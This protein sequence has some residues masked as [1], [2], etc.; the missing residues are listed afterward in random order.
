MATGDYVSVSSQS[1]IEAADLER[2]K[3]E[4]ENMP[5][6]ELKGLAKIYIK[7]RLDEQLAL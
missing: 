3:H 4:P 7:R 6:M 1:D 2:E 5:E